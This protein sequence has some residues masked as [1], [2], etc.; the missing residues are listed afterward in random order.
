[1]ILTF[2]FKTQRRRCLSSM[3]SSFSAMQ[4]VHRLRWIFNLNE[5]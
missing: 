3:S 5:L 2:S 4:P 1:M